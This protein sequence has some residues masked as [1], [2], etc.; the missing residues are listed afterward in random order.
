MTTFSMK[1][2]FTSAD[3]SKVLRYLQSNNYQLLGFKGATGPNQLTVG[4][5][6]WFSVP[7]LNIFSQVT[8]DYEPK[9]KVYVFNKSEIAANTTIQMQALSDEITL[10]KGLV[11]NTDG[12]FTAGSNP[13]SPNSIAL[14]NNRPIG[15]TPVTVGLAGLVNLP[16]GKKYLPFCA[17]TLTPQGSI[18]M[19]P[20]ETIVLFAAQLDLQS[21]NVQASASAPGCSF[22]FSNSTISYD[23]QVLDSSYEVTNAPA[24][25]PV[26]PVGSG[27]TLTQLLSSGSPVTNLALAASMAESSFELILPPNKGYTIKITSES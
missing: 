5:P 1:F 8:I 7:F 18:S 12:T 11:F 9:Y 26:T 15:T 3:Q 23:L 6:T 13:V 4:V 21:G 10:G 22:S 19:T 14:K 16:E 20:Q 27:Q 2:D 24:T 17:F 25:T